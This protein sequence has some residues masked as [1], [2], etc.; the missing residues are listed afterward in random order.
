MKEQKLVSG[1]ACSAGDLYQPEYP[2]IFQHENLLEEIEQAK[3]IEQQKL[4]NKLNHLNFSGGHVFTI[5]HHEKTGENILL[6]AVP[7]PCVKDDA[8]FRLDLPDD[9]SLDLSKHSLSYLLI[10]DGLNA[11]LTKVAD[12]KING[13]MLRISLPQQSYVIK[14]RVGKRYPCRGIKC[15]ATQ[16]NG[17]TVTG[18]LLDFTPRAFAARFNNNGAS[19]AENKSVVI[20]IEDNGSCLFSGACNCISD[21]VAAAD[22][23]VVFAPLNSHVPLYPKRKLRN[24]R[25]TILP[26]LAISFEHP[27]FKARVLR[28]ICEISTSGF[29]VLEDSDEEVFLPGMSIPSISIVFAGILKMNCSAQVIYRQENVENNTVQC[30]LAISDMDLPSYSY[31]NHILGFHLD[32][33]ASVSTQ[34]DMDAL[35]EFF[36]DTGFIYAEKYQHLESYRESFKETYRK[37]YQDNPGIARHFICE[38]NGRIYGHMSMVHAYNPSWVIHHFAARPM[39]SKIT[40]LMI[41]RQITH[42][43]NGFYHFPSSAMD[44]VMA[45]YRPENN[46]MSR[47]FGGFASYLNNPKGS[48]LDLFSYIHYKKESLTANLPANWSLRECLPSDFLKLVGFYEKHSGG[49]L[50]DALGLNSSMELLRESFVKAGFKRECKTFCLCNE[51]RTLAFFIINQTD[52]GLNLSDLINCIKIIITDEEKLAPE[53]LFAAVRRLSAFY[54]EEI[55]PL[56]IYP[57]NYLSE[58]GTNVKKHYQLWILKNDPYLDNYTEY[59]SNKF[60]M[61]YKAQ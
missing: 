12:S 28:D 56:L 57:D 11:I 17:H 9:D 6:T 47:I 19:F 61:K 2:L 18:E 7:Q 52:L 20:N 36:F 29:S 21:G 45:Y 26:S 55:V 23:R 3:S 60:R 46:I 35:W 51:E 30:G 5:F 1:T 59:M 33:N 38:K 40:G 49:L 31:L 44:Y 8:V 13:R 43:V 37:L 58:H 42:Y 39:G 53:M 22:G 41:L 14:K 48:S 24:P 25:Q 50:L 16:E 27:L 15:R 34:V 10:E 4:V 32:H 54:K